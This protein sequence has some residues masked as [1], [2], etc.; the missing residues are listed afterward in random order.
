MQKTNKLWSSVK[1]RR[2]D[3]TSN[4]PINYKG[5]AHTDLL[6]KANAFADYFSSVYDQDDPS[7]IPTLEGELFPDVQ[8]I[9]VNLEGV[10]Q[11]LLNLKPYKAAGPDNLPCYFLKEVA[12]EIAP[13]LC[14]ASLNQGMLPE[15][16]KSASVVPIYKKMIQATTD[17]CH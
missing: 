3:Q 11:L 15:I 16:W 4:G 9:H 14:Q 7:N 6:S 2:L 5:E 1:S 13:S 10:I 17:Q 8:Q 12:N